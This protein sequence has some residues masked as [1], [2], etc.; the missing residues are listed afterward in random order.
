MKATQPFLGMDQE[1]IAS[2]KS[3]EALCATQRMQA[4]QPTG[5]AERLAPVP[6]VGTDLVV[7]DLLG[8]LCPERDRVRA[9]LAAALSDADLPAGEGDLSRLAMLPTRAALKEWVASQTR[10]APEV[11]RPLVG[12]VLEDFRTRLLES[13]KSGEPVRVNPGAGTL[14]AELGMGGIQVAI[15]TELDGDIAM[16]FLRGAGWAGAGMLD[17]VVGADEVLVPRPGPGQVEEARR[18]CGLGDGARV[19]KVAGSADDARAGVLAGCVAVVSLVPDLAAGHAP[20]EDLGDL[21][22]RLLGHP[23]A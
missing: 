1:C 6:I 12:A 8:G 3:S 11:V 10:L 18:R 19:V 13:I 23:L 20:L 15:D 5:A 2:Q 16:A 4:V 21:A 7:L 9:C 17:A 22:E 14:M